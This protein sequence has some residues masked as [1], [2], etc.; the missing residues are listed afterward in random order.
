MQNAQNLT[1]QI[2]R[3][4]PEQRAVVEEFVNTLL[5]DAKP[6]PT[7]REALDRFKREHP[8]LLRLLAQ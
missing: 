7:F 8:E 6:R 2:L 5:K 3:L 1:Q 4:S